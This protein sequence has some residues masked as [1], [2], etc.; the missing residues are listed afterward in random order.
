MALT[1]SRRGVGSQ[2]P[3]SA[4][5]SVLMSGGFYMAGSSLHFTRTNVPAGLHLQCRYVLWLHGFTNRQELFLYLRGGIFIRHPSESRW[6]IDQR[7][8]VHTVHNLHPRAV[9]QL[10]VAG[11]GNVHSCYRDD[12][13]CGLSSHNYPVAYFKAP[14]MPASSAHKDPFPG[15]L[16]V[17]PF[18]THR[19]TG[20]RYN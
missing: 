18:A 14:K 1:T 10:W 11:S 3:T 20:P 6:L 4:W 7:T 15:L 8:R 9:A 2:L 19:I 12:A 13:V 5:G 16:V 17:Y